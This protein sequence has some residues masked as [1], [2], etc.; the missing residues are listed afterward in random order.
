MAL[1]PGAEYFPHVC[2]LSR[3]CHV[4]LFVAPC[5]VAC[6]SC[7]VHGIL[8]G[9]NTGLGSHFLLQGIF[10]T[11][12]IKPS[13]LVSP[14]LANR[15]FTTSATL[16]IFGITSHFMG[17]PG[18]SAGKESAYNK[19]NLG[20]V[21][22]LGRFSGEGNSLPTPVLMPGESHGQRSLVGCRPWGREESD[23]TE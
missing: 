8:Q 18:S 22:M 6:H 15:F 20:S 21:S 3:F 16:F 10:L 4:Q 14:A 11:Q 5:T 12:R 2:I 17:F 13:S 23:T 7:S 19:G 1:I 9:K